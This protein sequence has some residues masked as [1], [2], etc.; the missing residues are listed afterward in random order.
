MIPRKGW[1]DI[2]LS[3]MEDIQMAKFTQYPELREKLLATGDAELVYTNDC[4]DTYWGLSE[5]SGEN[6]L[7]KILMK[8]RGRLAGQ[9][10]RC[11]A[12][13]TGPPM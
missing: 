5:G 13:P 2:R 4:G 9:T 3:V 7:G 6:H 12:C 8:V 11:A 1:E 10:A